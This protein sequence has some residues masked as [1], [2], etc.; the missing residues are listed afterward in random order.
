MNYRNT[1][2]SFFSQ[3]VSEEAVCNSSQKSLISFVVIWSSLVL[4]GLV[5]IDRLLIG[6]QNIQSP[7]TGEN[8][9]VVVS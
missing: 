3:S 6:K 7:E 9:R 5:D 2:D 8:K 1:R 4:S